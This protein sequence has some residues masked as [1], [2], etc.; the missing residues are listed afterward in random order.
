M[1]GNDRV[2]VVLTGAEGQFDWDNFYMQCSD[3]G[4]RCKV[5]WRWIAADSE[6]RNQ[7]YC[8]KCRSSVATAKRRHRNRKATVA[9]LAR[10]KMAKL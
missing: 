8:S 7:P 2:R 3:C 5:E 4:E 9:R 6:Y 1:D 10:Y